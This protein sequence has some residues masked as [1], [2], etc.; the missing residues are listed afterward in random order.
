[1][2]YTYGLGGI[3]TNRE[4]CVA[5]GDSMNVLFVLLVLLDVG[6]AGLFSIEFPKVDYSAHQD[7]RLKAR[8]KLAQ[9]PKTSVHCLEL[10]NHTEEE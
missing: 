10:A 7:L 8:Q 1:M 5:G 9:M 4:I 6:A 3:C 2:I